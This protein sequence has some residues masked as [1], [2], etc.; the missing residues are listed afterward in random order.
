MQVSNT[1]LH[2][3]F[4][5]I[6]ILDR[7]MVYQSPAEKAESLNLVRTK[8]QAYPKTQTRR[9]PLLIADNYV[10]YSLIYIEFYLLGIF[11]VNKVCWT[12]A[13]LLKEA[14]EQIIK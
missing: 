7:V 9:K 13:G 5:C 11:P 3:L 1:R 12:V 8:L 10:R 6:D 4:E 2:C 14:T